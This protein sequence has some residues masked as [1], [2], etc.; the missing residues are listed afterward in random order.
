MTNKVRRNKREIED[1][2]DNTQKEKN[3]EALFLIFW[4]KMTNNY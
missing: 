2:L 1:L 4:Y 3:E